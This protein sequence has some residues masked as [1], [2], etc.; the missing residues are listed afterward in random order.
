MKF[1]MSK[2]IP[3]TILAVVT[4]A[5]AVLPAPAQQASAIKVTTTLHDD[6][7]RTVTRFDPD[8][9]ITEASK[10]SG[11]TLLQRSVFKLN[12]QN[13]PESGEIYNARGKLLW[14]VKNSRDEAGRVAEETR[15]NANDQFIVRLVYHYGTRN[16][17]V[18]ID[19]YDASGNLMPTGPAR[20]D[21]KKDRRSR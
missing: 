12:D 21:V 6:G 5:A 4:L 15:F 20:R 9:R 3:V 11:D 17:I 13:Q 14:K 16:Q 2:R 18:K 1:H 19:A 8:A 10:Y 7:T